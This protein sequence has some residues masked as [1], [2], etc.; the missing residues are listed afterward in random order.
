MS[1]SQTTQIIRTQCCETFA[2][3]DCWFDREQ[4]MR[5]YQP[6]SGGWSVEQVLEHVALT[7]HFLLLTLRK[8]TKVAE[9]RAQRGDL[10]P[11]GE[12]DLKSIEI[13]GERGSFSWKH[14]P[15]MTP[16]G[17]LADVRTQLQQQLQECLTLLE[18]IKAG[19]GALCKIQMTVHDLG[20]I[21]LYQWLYFIV[22]H[23]RRHLQQLESIAAE[24]RQANQKP[25]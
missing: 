6:L 19:I 15:H 12:S 7:N 22:Q 16:S 3:L 10:L 9:R 23:A 20:K 8:W 21:D 25:S 14:P 2:Q 4:D 1:F 5:K 18:R 11:E 13:I 17:E 24:Y